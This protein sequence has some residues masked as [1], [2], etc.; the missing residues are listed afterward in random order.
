MSSN[1]RSTVGQMDGLELV[2]TINFLGEAGHR[3]CY[4]NDV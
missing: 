3:L 1:R 4:K 2:A